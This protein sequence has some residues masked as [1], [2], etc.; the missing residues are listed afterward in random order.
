MWP[1]RSGKT[2]NMISSHFRHQGSICSS[3]ASPSAGAPLATEEAA[4]PG[5]PP[6]RDQALHVGD[7]A[8]VEVLRADQL[9]DGRLD[10]RVADHD[11]GAEGPLPGCNARDRAALQQDLL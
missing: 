1:G 11:R 8:R 7:V 10:A 4:S 5:N 9:E 2:R 3:V 6:G